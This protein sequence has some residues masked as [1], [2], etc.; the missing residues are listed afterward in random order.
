M[1]SKIIVIS[2][3]VGLA[4]TFTGC[5]FLD[6]VPDNTVEVGSL[7]E[8]RDKA[9]SALSTCYRYLPNHEKLHESMSLAG[10]E[11]IGRL[12]A[13]VADVRW[14]TRGEKIMRG[15]NNSSDPILNY[16]SGGGGAT[17][18]YQGIRVCNIFFENIE[19]VPD[20][21][22]AER[23][24]WIAQVKI[25]KAYYHFYLMRLYGPIII[26]DVNLEPFSEV[27]EV[28]QERQTID[29]CF[30]Y[31][32]NLINE[33]LYDAN[34]NPNTELAVE[35]DNA[36]YG[37]IDQVNARAIKA[38]ILLTRASPLFN[39]NSEYFSNFRNKEGQT[40][41]PMQYDPEKW[42]QALDGIKD[43]IDYAEA[44][45]KQ[46]YT[47]NGQPKFWDI[48]NFK[49][50]EII[51]YCY[52]KRFSIVSP[53]NDELLWGYS[54]LDYEGQGGFAHA[55]N[56][57]SVAEPTTAGFAW[58]WLGADYRMDELFY[59][60]NGVP[61]EDDKTF[62]YDNRLEITTIPSDNYYK[63]YMQAGER[64]VKLHLNREP[65]FYA[66]MVV[67][68]SVWR[69]HDMAND[70]KMRYNEFPGGRGSQHTTDFYWT[71]LGV[72][73]LVHPESGT[74]HW[75]RVVKFPYPILRLSDLYLMYAEAYNEYHGPA[76]EAYEYLN[77]VR[78]TGGLKP[79]EEV[80]SDV[81]IVK[82][83]GKH[84]TKEG[85]RDIIHRERIIELSFEGHKYFD[86]LRWKEADRYF[87]SPMRGWNTTGVD[88]EQFYV[89]MTLQ[90]RVWQTPRDYLM[91][92]PIS[93]INRNPNLAQNPG[94]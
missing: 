5:N 20:I 64:T 35:R 68:R 87:L 77:R 63:G 27:E 43:A 18:L 75:A 36:Y 7:F 78:S 93:D 13:E 76:P 56:M 8:N 17:S 22:P 46:L 48:E 39:G 30:N 57:R 54:G 42:K 58:Q 83:P 14:N 92:I 26:A 1:K 24:D 59:T 47:F 90:P 62:E 60:K 74:G 44:R 73:K 38:Q 6:I 65:R 67:D 40:F 10:D 33:V 50:S 88:P 61:I 49:E 81:N 4:A 34:G 94:W 55:T 41:F 91:P 31:T 37:Q 11:W 52:N 80:W 12:D 3:I 19:N 25:L 86:V 9:L 2:F 51:Q 82:T 23:L 70:V 71:G 89:L 66:W 28:R 15:W 21:T 85:L 29:S 32:L 53:W 79:I 69:T 16:W 45:G 84:L 72:K